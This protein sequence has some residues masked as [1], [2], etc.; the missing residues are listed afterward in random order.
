MKLFGAK[1]VLQ[2]VV[3]FSDQ[4]HYFHM[5]ARLAQETPGAVFTNQ[6]ENLA[7]A[8][9]HY[10]TTGPEVWKQSNGQIDGLVLSC[11]TGGTMGGLSVFLK[12][13]NPQIKVYLIDPPGSGLFSYFKHGKFE[14]RGS[15]ITEGIGIARLT[16]NF[17]QSKIDGAFEGNDQEA[18]DMAYYLLKHEGLWIGPS[19]ALNVV[20]AVKLARILGPGKV[21][22]TILCDGGDRYRTTLFDCKFLATKN[23]SIRETDDSLSWIS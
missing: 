14:T 18:V 7:N 6:F 4:R 9:S 5:A 8:I 12:E 10:T 23:L 19:A 15:S 2:P 21:I 20:G 16:A 22:V 3:P 13:Q 11:G 17:A 1:V